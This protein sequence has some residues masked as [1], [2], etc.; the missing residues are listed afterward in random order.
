MVMRL[1]R[2]R[3]WLKRLLQDRAAWAG[4]NPNAAAALAK[5]LAQRRRI[6]PNHGGCDRR[7]RGVY[8]AK[9]RR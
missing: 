3:G 5:I 1:K 2:G 7:L 9:I 8:G 6:G 4:G